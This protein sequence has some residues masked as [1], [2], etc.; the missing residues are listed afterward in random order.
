MQ[1]TRP[2]EHEGNNIQEIRYRLK[3]L[4]AKAA[5]SNTMKEIIDDDILQDAFPPS[6]TLNHKTH[7]VIYHV[8]ETS[9]TGRAYLDLTGRFPYRSSRGA[10]YIMVAYHYD[11]DAVLVEPLQNR[12]AQS[13]VAVW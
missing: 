5:G 12:N 1:S 6:D 4:K 2:D 8:H 3:K 10:Q 13:L 11:S 7:S 9:S